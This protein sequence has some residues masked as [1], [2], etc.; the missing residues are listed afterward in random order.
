[1]SKKIQNV[2]SKPNVYFSIDDEN[3]PYK[4]AKGKR[5]V[6]T[7]EDPNAVMPV[8]EKVNLKYIGKRVHQIAKMTIE[9]VRSGNEV[10]P[11]IKPK[12]FSTWDFGK[13]QD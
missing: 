5:T 4:G 12:F 1:M 6:T 7:V 3:I 13:E 9:N 2:R 11:K 8:A 10:L